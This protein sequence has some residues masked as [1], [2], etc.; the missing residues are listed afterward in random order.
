MIVFLP[1][2][3]FSLVKSNL[4]DTWYFI[5]CDNALLCSDLVKNLG[6]ERVYYINE[7]KFSA[8]L[9][10]GEFNEIKS[11]NGIKMHK[12]KKKYKDFSENPPDSG[13]LYAIM[14][15]FPCY[16]EKYH[17]NITKDYHL[18][19][20]KENITSFLKNNRCVRAIDRINSANLHMR[21]SRSI[22]HSDEID[23]QIN[24]FTPYNI[25][26]ILNEKG[27]KGNGQ[28]A[29]IVDTGIDPNLCWFYDSQA[30]GIDERRYNEHRKIIGYS[31]LL[32]L[33]DVSGGHGSF[34]SG[35][36]AADAFCPNPFEMFC[37]G[38]YY[39]GVAPG[40]RLYIQPFVGKDG[41]LT[42][43]DDFSD[44][45]SIPSA[46]CCSA[47][48]NSWT[49]PP[50]KIL[51]RAYDSLAYNNPQILAVFPSGDGK[52][53]GS[54]ADS[55]NVLTVGSIYGNDI[56]MNGV[57]QSSTVIITI[58]HSDSVIAFCDGFHGVNYL[59]LVAKVE[60]SHLE[61]GYIIGLN[62][63]NAFIDE[64][65]DL[66]FEFFE[67]S[68]IILSFHSKPYTSKNKTVTIIRIAPKYRS[69]FLTGSI[70][71][72]KPYNDKCHSIISPFKSVSYSATKKH[73]SKK[74]KPD[75][76]MPAGPVFGPSANSFG[77]GKCGR[78]G[79]MIG[80]GTSV[81][82]AL[83]V[84]DIL[85]IRQWLK[86]GWYPNGEENKENI[87]KTSNHMLKAILSH[88]ASPTNTYSENGF[89]MPQ[90]D[91]FII[92]PDTYNTTNRK[93]GIRLFYEQKLSG[94]SFHSYIFI[95]EYD[96]ILKVTMSWNDPPMDPD[97]QND[98][99]F[100]MDIRIRMP[101]GS[102]IIGNHNIVGDQLFDYQNTVKNIEVF[103]NNSLEYVIFV[104]S[105]S[106]FSYTY[107]NYTLVVS[108][109]FDHFNKTQEP[110]SVNYLSSPCPFSCFNNSICENGWC[111]CPD[112]YFGYNCDKHIE[113]HNLNE[114]FSISNTQ[115]HP[116]YHSFMISRQDFSNKIKIQTSLRD[117]FKYFLIT[118]DTLSH[119]KTITS[120]Q[121]S[122]SKN[123]DIVMQTKSFAQYDGDFYLLF[124]VVP[125]SNEPNASASI[126]FV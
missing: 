22:S 86:H 85:L 108:G 34:V 52:V 81:S 102:I 28:C 30:T 7:H 118:S 3:S 99:L 6:K 2:F 106:L 123:Q 74:I 122:Y 100:E 14:V 12:I 55:K 92:F 18:I 87:I 78:N 110:K 115:D 116:S 25:R 97:S 53:I 84:G 67:Y 56:V 4:K 29:S 48:L 107:V 50:S 54:P 32:N 68:G 45:L 9:K 62:K 20:I 38:S 94:F 60:K 126:R 70:V 114:Q 98:V 37:E 76:V 65:G 15:S 58:D 24:S 27:I 47:Q 11:L 80:E 63:G 89:G 1:I 36:I 21:Y 111:K 79:V 61:Q 83:S 10:E 119:L 95:P 73:G 26:S 23:M 109:P 77:E 19:H 82:S 51:T 125:S 103:V 91:K 105:G 57:D 112:G 49:T 69:K 5:S 93:Y 101:N 44:V 42:F 59:D 8:F 66:P 43:P 16:L 90:L 117:H 96:G 17:V 46:F 64:K 72:I 104:Q 41:R 75:I 121:F 35:I 33:S 124:A 120:D 13:D 39:N 88:I 40:A 113:H 71:N 31:E